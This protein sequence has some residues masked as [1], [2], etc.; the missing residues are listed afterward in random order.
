[1]TPKSLMKPLIGK[2]SILLVAVLA[3]AVGATGCDRIPTMDQLRA[4]R[5]F[6]EANTAY[7]NQ[8]YEDAIEAYSQ[9]M[10]HVPPDDPVIQTTLRFFTASSHHLLYSQTA[11]AQEDP[12]IQ[13]HLEKA[14]ALFE[15]TIE[16]VNQA[17]VDPDLDPEQRELIAV[18]ERYASEQ[19]AAIY[20]DNLRDLAG[21]EKYFLR[22]IE[23]DPNEPA[24]YYALAD[25]YERFHTE[26][27]PLL[28]KVVATYEKPVELNPEDPIAYRQVAGLLNK[29]GRFEETMEWLAR[30]RDV[31]PDNPEGYYLIS[32]YYWDKVYRDPDLSQRQ[33]AEFID[34]GIEQLDAALALND[35]Y[36]DALVYKN[37]LLREKAKI[38]PRN[39]NAFIAE[40][41]EYRARAIALREAQQEAQRAAAAAA[42]EAAASGA[43]TNEPQ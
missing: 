4:M 21:A 25:A 35:E 17:L 34:L 37:L 1:M 6:G 2:A 33:R 23:L 20:R 16:T 14:R 41:D 27:N 39:A 31:N 18:Y 19:L 12:E 38:N 22:L 32:T 9:A 10:E 5:A 11:S 29:L 36:V 3:L 26:E 7:G 42:A 24:R 28:D 8:E 43:A 40:A 13:A 15:E 30:A